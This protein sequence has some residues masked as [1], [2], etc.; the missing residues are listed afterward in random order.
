MT[1][2]TDP[3]SGVTAAVH[4]CRSCHAPVYWGFTEKGKRCPYDVVDGTATR[5]S[6]FTTCP[7]AQAWSKK[8]AA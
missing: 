5:T 8:G 4:E 7:Q 6:H 3:K 2:V 1:T